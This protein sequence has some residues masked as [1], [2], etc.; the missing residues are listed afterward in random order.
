[1]KQKA[2]CTGKLLVITG[3]GNYW[4][5][6]AP[7]LLVIWDAHAE[8]GTR[9]HKKSGTV[10]LYSCDIADRCCFMGV[11]FVTRC[12]HSRPRSFITQLHF[13]PFE[14]LSNCCSCKPPESWIGGDPK[15]VVSPSVGYRRLELVQ[16]R[17]LLRVFFHA[18]TQTRAGALRT[19]TRTSSRTTTRFQQRQTHVMS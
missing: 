17:S 16:G 14:Q 2:L 8:V 5:F 7:K 18:S 19:S 6:S 1:M 4:Q 12:T 10:S 11:W 3:N 9:F 13:Y 15:V